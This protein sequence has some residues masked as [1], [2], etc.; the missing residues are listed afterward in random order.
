MHPSPINKEKKIWQVFFW[1]DN[2]KIPGSARLAWPHSSAGW[3]CLEL[4]LIM[5]LLKQKR[6]L[7]VSSV[8][9]MTTV[10]SGRLPAGNALVL[11]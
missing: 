9:R 1:V 2:L 4:S 3:S 7:G 10:I 5:L 6:F 11:Q 8:V